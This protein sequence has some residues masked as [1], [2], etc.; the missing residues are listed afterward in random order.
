MKNVIQK[1][2]QQLRIRHRAQEKRITKIKK[3][4]ESQRAKIIITAAALLLIL[5]HSAI[6]PC[7]HAHAAT[8]QI[9]W[10]E[11]HVD[12]SE[13][14]LRIGWGCPIETRIRTIRQGNAALWLGWINFFIPIN[15]MAAM[16]VAW[17]AAIGLYYLASIVLRWF[18]VVS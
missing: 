10:Q 9:P 8:P 5:T 6:T 11:I 1:I 2:K 3:E 17:V 13:E 15:E 12:E 7:N 16:L 18:K 4:G 14:A